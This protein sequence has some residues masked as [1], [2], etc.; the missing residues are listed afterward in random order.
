MRRAVIAGNWKLHKTIKESKE[1]VSGLKTELSD[2][3]DIDIV[4]PG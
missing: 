4:G 2:V 3:R 1:L